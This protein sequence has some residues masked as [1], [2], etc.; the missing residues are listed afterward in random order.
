MAVKRP[1][2]GPASAASARPVM[3][4]SWA[5][6]KLACALASLASGYTSLVLVVA[7]TGFANSTFHRVDCTI[8]KPRVYPARL[9]Y[10][11]RV[12][13]I[14]GNLGRTSATA[15]FATVSRI[16]NWRMA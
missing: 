14:T 4:A 2:V 3:F 16:C 7:L 9:G 15:F 6:I 1:N 5:T 12:H 11:F 13:G 10:A 8:M